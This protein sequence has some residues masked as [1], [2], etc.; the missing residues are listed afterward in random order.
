M[1]GCGLMKA[2]IAFSGGMDSTALLIN[3]LN[4]NY[5]ITCISFD[6]G[7]KHKI[8]IER[9]KANIN[10]LNSIGHIIE[11]KIIDMTNSFEIF[12]SAL[13]N[14]DIDIPEGHYEEAQM[15]LTVV[16]N[17][18]AIFSS[19]MYGYAISLV[20]KYN[21]DVKIGLGVHSG[22]HAIYPDCRPKFYE[23]IN[24]SFALGNWK[25]ENVTFYL[26][27]IDAD[28]KYILNDLMTSCKILNINSNTILKNTL[29]SYNP[30]YKGKSSGKSGSDVERILAFDSLGLEDPIEYVKPWKEVL[31]D[32]LDTELRHHVTR[33]N[34]TERAFTGRYDKFS[35]TGKYRCYNCN[36]LLFTSEMK[37]NSGCG[38][39]AFHSEH[40]SANI[41]RIIDAS[42]GMERVEVRCSSCDSHLGH[43]FEDG[44]SQFGGERYC[45]NSV[46]LDFEEELK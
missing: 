9:A 16:P 19:I 31:L 1:V 38:W 34:G 18:N 15:K 11:H 26:P 21:C 46:S 30:D 20:N 4:R 3:M 5:D 24:K 14:D 35:L 8:E 17:R 25:S 23:S 27:F 42:H 43:V 36:K 41:S 40:D 7:Q 44:P 39:P 6:Y 45:I 28:K 29:T 22:D 13:L 12:D 32:A 33:E 2:V 10:Y 37:Y